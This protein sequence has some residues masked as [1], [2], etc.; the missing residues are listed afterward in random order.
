MINLNISV[1]SNI[2]NVHFES[3]P[4]LIVF[5]KETCDVV[6]NIVNVH[7]ESKPQLATR[8][9]DIAHSCVKYR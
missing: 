7:F 9:T 8:L 6:S 3:K 1:V 4:Q 2:V 5:T